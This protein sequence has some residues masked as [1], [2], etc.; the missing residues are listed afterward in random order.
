MCGGLLPCHVVKCMCRGLPRVTVQGGVRRFVGSVHQ[1]GRYTVVGTL[2]TDVD[3]ERIWS[4]LTDYH[5]MANLFSSIED[6]SV[7]AEGSSLVLHQVG[8]SAHF[9]TVTLCPASGG[10][11]RALK[12]LT[13]CPA[14]GGLV[15]A[16]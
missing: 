8:C 12:T 13:L 14:L 4:I 15:R 9:K 5:N 10:L 3:E 6:I 1:V 2:V 11:V 16:L 7:S